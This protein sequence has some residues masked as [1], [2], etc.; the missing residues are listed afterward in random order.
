MRFSF[1]CFYS[2]Q[3]RGLG[4]NVATEWKILDGRESGDLM[5]LWLW[6]SRKPLLSHRLCLLVVRRRL[7]SMWSKSHRTRR[8]VLPIIDLREES[9]RIGFMQK[10][11]SPFHSN[12]LLSSHCETRRNG[13]LK[14]FKLSF[15]LNFKESPLLKIVVG[16]DRQEG[17][18]D[19]VKAESGW[20]YDWI[21]IRMKGTRI[22]RIII[23]D[24]GALCELNMKL[25]F[26]CLKPFPSHFAF[27]ISISLW[28]LIRTITRE[29]IQPNLNR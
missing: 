3:L 19:G 4:L 18:V 16:V 8:V 23:R 13:K 26:H 21:F 15:E 6:S 20:G 12:L 7:R 17:N 1:Q 29:L 22:S 9:I 25:D 10:V 28:D 27:S 2:S 24:S 11:P 14:L 5:G